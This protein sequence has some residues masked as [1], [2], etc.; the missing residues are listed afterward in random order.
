MVPALVGAGQPLDVLVQLQNGVEGDGTAYGRI[1]TVHRSEPT[2]HPRHRQPDVRLPVP[3]LVRRCSVVVDGE[4][5]QTVRHRSV[6]G[7]GRGVQALEFADQSILVLPVVGEQLDDPFVAVR[8]RDRVHARMGA[9][10]AHLPP[11]ADRP[12]PFR[13]RPRAQI[14]GVVPGERRRLDRTR[15]G[16]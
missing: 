2:A 3:R 12:Q 1:D 13:Q 15:T 7:A 16:W 14:V 6:P 8:A 11:L 4:P 10:S 9:G 5:N